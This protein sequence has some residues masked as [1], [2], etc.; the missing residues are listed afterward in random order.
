[1]AS[2]IFSF[3]C[4]FIHLFVCMYMHMVLIQI[5]YYSSKYKVANAQSLKYIIYF[6]C[7]SEL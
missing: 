4:S 7:L 6:Y 3:I 5:T 1:M 2:S